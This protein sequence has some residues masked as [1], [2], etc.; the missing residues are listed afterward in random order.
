MS[1]TYSL[2]TYRIVSYRI[3][4]EG[5]VSHPLILF[6]LLL[7]FIFHFLFR[8]LHFQ[9]LHGCGNAK[10]GVMDGE[11]CWVTVSRQGCPIRK[12]KGLI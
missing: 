1:P 11:R 7:V 2:D 10:F 3:G 5:V 4:K 8:S 9:R 6:F 12:S